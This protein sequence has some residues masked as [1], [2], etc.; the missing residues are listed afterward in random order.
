M[1]QS[2]MGVR[3]DEATQKR[4]KKLSAQ[5]DRSP[6]YLM[7]EAIEAYL[8]REEDLEAE[9]A[10]IRERWKHFELTGETVS[11]DEMVQW[12]ASLQTDT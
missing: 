2:T 9:K 7:K 6:H 11:Q 4:L 5:R 12:A 10:L 8:R 1:A 3:L